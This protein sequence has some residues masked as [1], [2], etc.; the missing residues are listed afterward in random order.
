MMTMNERI[1]RMTFAD[2]VIHAETQTIYEVQ[3]LETTGEN[4]LLVYVSG[5]MIFQDIDLMTLNEACEAERAVNFLKRTYK[6]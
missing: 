4:Q 5:D 1:K 3:S 6:I 2:K